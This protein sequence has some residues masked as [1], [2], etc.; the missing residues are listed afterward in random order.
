M[1][2]VAGFEGDEGVG[3]V[4]ELPHGTVE[5]A[6]REAENGFAGEDGLPDAFPGDEWLGPDGFEEIAESLFD[7]STG[8]GVF[9][10]GAFAWAGFGAGVEEP[11]VGLV[12][13]FGHGWDESVVVFSTVD[14]GIEDKAAETVGN[15]LSDCL[16]S[17]CA[18]A[19]AE[20]PNLC[21]PGIL[22]IQHCLELC[23]VNNI[24]DVGWSAGV[25]DLC[26]P[27]HPG[28]SQTMCLG[29]LI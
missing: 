1:G 22:S 25:F 7:L 5:H 11:G 29:S 21:V 24:L 10:V 13:V 4:F 8:L 15:H 3:E 9:G 19:D 20:S 2:H 14:V 6:E 27:S 12:G 28:A 18:V 26:V 17:D 16:T 23:E